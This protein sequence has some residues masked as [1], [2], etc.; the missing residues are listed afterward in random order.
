MSISS[1]TVML[2]E[3]MCQDVV[4]DSPARESPW[5]LTEN[6]TPGPTLGLLSQNPQVKPR[7]LHVQLASQKIL[8]LSMG[9]RG[10]DSGLVVC[11]SF[12]GNIAVAC[13]LSVS[14]CCRPE[15]L[16]S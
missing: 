2:W 14:M 5:E 1:P 4:K 7:I 16:S 8:M 15:A 12:T 11:V 10:P 9:H 3:N 13:Y 6:Q